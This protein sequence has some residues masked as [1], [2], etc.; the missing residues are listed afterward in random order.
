MEELRPIGKDNHFERCGVCVYYSHHR[1]E[2]PC[3]NCDGKNEFY[4]LYRDKPKRKK[5]KQ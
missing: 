2:F 1:Y 3:I 5:P 4:A